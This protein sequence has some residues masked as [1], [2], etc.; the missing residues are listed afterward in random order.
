[1][2]KVISSVL[3]VLMLFSICSVACGAAVSSGTHAAVRVKPISTVDGIVTFEVTYELGTIGEMGMLGSFSRFSIGWDSDVFEPIETIEGIKTF[4]QT[5]TMLISGYPIDD[6]VIPANSDI[7]LTGTESLSSVDTAKGWDSGFFVTMASMDGNSEIYDDYSSEKAAFAFQL[8]LK[9]GA[10][11][12]EYSVGVTDWSI[13]NGN[14][15][16]LEYTD[17]WGVT[18]YETLNPSDYSLSGDKLFEFYDAVYEV[19]A[20]GPE[21]VALDKTMARMDKWEDAETTNIFDGG[22]IGQINNVNL[23]FTDG[24][25]N[26][27]DTIEVYANGQKMGNA[28]Q[29]YKVNDTT[30]Q[31]RA[32]IKNMDKTINY[33]TDVEY[34]FRV[35]MKGAYADSGVLTAKK[36]VSAE[37]IFTTA[38]AAYKAANA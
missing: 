6:I 9:D 28:Y 22:L 38:Y 10:E 11:P 21:V 13:N 30:Y 31:F 35:T 1:M 15:C 19:K 7:R 2:K 20:A 29:V 27:I 4:E 18:P 33:S 17:A 26:E 34:E 8:K 24:E 14:F 23:T 25:C 36:T 32:V 12:G 5:N 16:I 3:A 37:T